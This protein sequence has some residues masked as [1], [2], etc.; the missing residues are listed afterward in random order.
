VELAGMAG[1]IVAAA[2]VVVGLLVVAGE[3]GDL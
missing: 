2:C 1:F 3:L